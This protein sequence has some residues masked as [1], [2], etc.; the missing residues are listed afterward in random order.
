MNKIKETL[1]DKTL[2]RYSIFI[3]FT[4]A[5]LVAFYV[6]ISNFVPILEWLSLNLKTFLGTLTPLII[7]IVLAYLI[8]PLETI[9]NGKLISKFSHN[10]SDLNKE[11]KRIKRNRLI[12]TLLSYLLIIAIVIGLLYFFISL[13]IGKFVITGVSSLYDASIEYINRNEALLLDFLSDLKNNPALGDTV[14]ELTDILVEWWK[15]NL[16]IS[17]VITSITSI[18]GSIFTFAIGVIISIYLVLDKD[19]FIGLL[20]KFITLLVSDEKALKINS[21]CTEINVV[22][23]SFIK[24]V[25]IDAVAVAILSSIFLT[26]LG[27]DFAVFVGIFAG[28]C[29][30]IPYFGPILGMIP[31]FLIGAFTDSLL[32]GVFAIALLVIVQQIDCNFIYPRVVGSSTGLHPLFVLL[33]V[34]IIGSYGGLAGMIIAVPIAGILAIFIKKWASWAETRKNNNNP[35]NTKAD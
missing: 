27:V 23:S 6:V 11:V 7:G 30:V 16:S 19:F 35:T 9:I 22:L 34:S 24:G 4:V 10:K 25:F 12:S 14:N 13:I 21:T 3:L 5:L 15:N 33:A 18:G 29:N 20:K 8:S 2:M 28:L 26:I 32:Q 17:G 1:K 31:A